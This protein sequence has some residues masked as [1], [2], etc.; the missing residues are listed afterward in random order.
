MR[1]CTL[2]NVTACGHIHKHTLGVELARIILLQLEFRPC[3]IDEVK[4]HIKYLLNGRF[5]DKTAF[6]SFHPLIG[7]HVCNSLAGCK[8]VVAPEYDRASRSSAISC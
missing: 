2:F 3:I 7:H 5:K 8:D 6:E 1:L 4:C